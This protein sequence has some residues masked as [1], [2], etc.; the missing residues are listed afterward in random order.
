MDLMQAAI[1][2]YEDMGFARAP[3]LDFSPAPGFTVKGYR[4]DLPAN[5]PAGGGAPGAPRLP[6]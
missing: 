3:E 5:P 4:L 2:L 6:A 1:R